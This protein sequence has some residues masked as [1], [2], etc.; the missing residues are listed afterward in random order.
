MTLTKTE[1][2]VGITIH[3]H[4][5]VLDIWDRT[6]ISGVSIINVKSGQSIATDAQGKFST[7]CGMRDTL[8]LFLPGYKAQ[9]F[10]M[11]DSASKEEYFAEYYLDRLTAG[12][13]RPI[14][15]HPHLTL[16]DIEK[17]RNKLGQIPKELQK[18][19]IVITSPISALYDL[20]SNRAKER[21]KLREQI[22]DDERRR[23]YRELFDYY[24]EAGLFDLPAEYYEP[25]ITYLNLPID[26]L[27]YNTDYTI[28]KAILDSYKKFGM[29]KGFIK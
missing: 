22:Q 18:P 28:T 1:A 7:Y 15:V 10:S 8:F 4:G 6:P 25:F 20:L 12:P 21:N 14:I 17:E 11:A 13:S 24:K 27:R 23:I 16:T 19:E 5:T 9:R 29:E 2:Q 3:I 26:F